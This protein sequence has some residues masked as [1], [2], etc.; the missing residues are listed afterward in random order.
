MTLGDW[1]WV[2]APGNVGSMLLTGPMLVL[3]MRWAGWGPLRMLLV[4]LVGW[5]V[6]FVA[7]MVMWRVFGYQAGYPGF[8][9]L[10]PFALPVSFGNFVAS[11]WLAK[12]SAAVPVGRHARPEPAPLVPAAHPSVTPAQIEGVR[13]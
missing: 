8:K 13:S 5:C 11:L 6:L 3:I 1:S 9:Y 4:G 2:A 10:Q 12:Q 7:Q